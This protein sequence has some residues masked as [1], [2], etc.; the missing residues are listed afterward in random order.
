MTEIELPDGKPTVPR[1]FGFAAEELTLDMGEGAKS[2][3]GE[4]AKSQAV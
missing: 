4:K 3:K 1:R 2:L